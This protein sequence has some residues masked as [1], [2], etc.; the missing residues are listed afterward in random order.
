MCI[1]PIS[2]KENMSVIKSIISKLS[3]EFSCVVNVDTFNT[4]IG[5][6]IAAAD[7][8]NLYILSF[9][10]S[11]NLEKK[12]ETL[13]SQLKCKFVESKNKLIEKIE[14]EFSQYF[15]G[16][17]KKFSVPVKFFGTE[18]QNVISFFLC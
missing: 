12:F 17:L 2:V 18:F 13:F 8:D 5:K 10:D 9:E 3:T 15:K 1:L 16:N 4:P 11:K 6:V 14:E 7:D